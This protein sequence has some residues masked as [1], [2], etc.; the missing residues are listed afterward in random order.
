[1]NEG[2]QNNQ[3]ARPLDTR[4]EPKVN[5]IPLGGCGEIGKN[6]TVIEC[7]EDIILI[8]AGLMFPEEDM[9]GVDIII[10]DFSYILR[11]KK[12]IR[13]IILTHGH[14][15]HIGALP[16]L[17]AKVNAPIYGTKLTLGLLRNKLEEFTHLLKTRPRLNIINPE[18]DILRFGIF[19]VE[20]FRVC[21]SIVD[22]VG[23]AIT[24]PCGLILHSGDFK[25]DHTPV[26]GRKMDLHKIAEFGNRGVAL[27]MSDSTNVE[28]S[29][30]TLSE[31]VVGETLKEVFGEA[32]GRIIV[33]TFSSSVSRLKQVMDTAILYNRKIVITGM[34]MA[35][36]IRISRELGY[37]NIA[38]SAFVSLNQVG[39]L[40]PQKTVIITTGSQG[41]PMSAL[42]RMA[43]STHKQIRIKKGDTVIISARVIPGNENAISRNINNLFKLGAD[44]VYEKVS[45]IHV[46]GHASQEELKLILNMA[47]PKYFMP[48]HGE[49]RHLVHHAV[50][51]TKVCVARDNAF[52]VTN[53]SKLTITRQ[54]A[55]ISG[56]VHAGI[57]MVDGKGVGDIGTMVLR[58][59]QHLSQGGMV[60]VIA[61][62]NRQTGALLCEPEIVSRGF[63]YMQRSDELIIAAK[64]KIHEVLKDFAKRKAVDQMA[65]KEAIRSTLKSFFYKETARRP[66]ILPVV[67]EI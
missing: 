15:D 63:V 39:K 59:R 43:D 60:I 62:L 4:P 37:L 18:K 57:T 46:S 50:L 61:I 48:I 58:D 23:L 52:V 49:H 9:L 6:M 16:Y 5:I 42:S 35:N 19:K 3:P 64:K 41:E 14:E 66:M 11:K 45:E 56:Q 25:I 67:L 44:V 1:M 20:F 2:R 24:T 38:E 13:A 40:L 30:Y 33:A 47:R 36:V 21:H 31:K 27:L 55:S 32:K 7:G 53:G 54:R 10:P 29:G 28:S 51:A 65:I 34:S 8:D 26:D 17:L 12:N 22:G